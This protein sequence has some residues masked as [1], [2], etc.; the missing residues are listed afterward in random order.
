MSMSEPS[1]SITLWVIADAWRSFC[2]EDGQFE[3]ECLPG[4]YHDFSH[5]GDLANWYFPSCDH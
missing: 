1:R 5:R 4:H 3:G 2:D